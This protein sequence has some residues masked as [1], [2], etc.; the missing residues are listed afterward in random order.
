MEPYKS[1]SSSFSS[2]SVDINMYVTA[3]LNA[4]RIKRTK[5]CEVWA[6]SLRREKEL[7][8]ILCLIVLDYHMLS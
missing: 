3:L 4:V 8:K 6:V 2:E 7:N 1:I 5:Q